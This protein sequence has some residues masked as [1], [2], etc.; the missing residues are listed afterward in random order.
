MIILRDERG[1]ESPILCQFCGK[2]NRWHEGTGKAAT[3]TTSAGDFVCEQCRAEFE[4]ALET[5][6]EEEGES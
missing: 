5:G 2:G 6:E 4:N 1:N 3:V